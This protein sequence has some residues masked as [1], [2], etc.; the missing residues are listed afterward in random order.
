MLSGKTAINTPSACGSE[1]KKTNLNVEQVK[2]WILMLF[3]SI[4]DATCQ[5]WSA[6]FV[7]FFVFVRLYFH[8]FARVLFASSGKLCTNVSRS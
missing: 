4:R 8:A 7:N 5:K 6:N 3:V 2:V 1:E